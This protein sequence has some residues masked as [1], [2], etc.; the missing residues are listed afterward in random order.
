MSAKTPPP[1]RNYAQMARVVRDDQKQLFSPSV[2][3]QLAKSYGDYTPSM[4]E[5]R[6]RSLDEI[7]INT[8][9]AGQL[10]QS[11]SDNY[12]NRRESTVIYHQLNDDQQQYFD[13]VS[14]N[15]SP[16]RRDALPGTKTRAYLNSDAASETINVAA[17]YDSNHYEYTGHKRAEKT[18]NHS[19]PLAKS[20][21]DIDVSFT[22]EKP[23]KKQTRLP[24][25]YGH[26]LEGTAETS[27]EF[28]LSF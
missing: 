11:A 24:A 9:P 2:P 6:I 13:G 14:P 28:D 4:A 1:L 25:V 12:Y 3:Y 7:G 23:I 19:A 5:V 17:N 27:L 26:S 10:Q 22:H 21:S 20:A 15:Q 16:T 8:R 18:K